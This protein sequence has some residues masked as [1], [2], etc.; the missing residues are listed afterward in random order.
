[1]EKRVGAI[2]L[3]D[4]NNRVLFQ[5]RDNK[6]NI[7][8]PN[9]WVPPGGHA[10]KYEKIASCAKREFFEET[11]YIC[12]NIKFICNKKFNLKKLNTMRVYFYWENYDHKQKIKCNEGQKAKF[13][14][15]QNFKKKNKPEYLLEIYRAVLKLKLKKEH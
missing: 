6:A 12:K 15:F 1:M 7:S 14:S 2:F 11:R 5:L 3:F 8:N 10:K 9:M 4:K 13:L